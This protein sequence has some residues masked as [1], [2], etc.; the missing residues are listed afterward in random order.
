MVLYLVIVSCAS[1]VQHYTAVTDTPRAGQQS[2]GSVQHWSN[3][4]DSVHICGVCGF[5]QIYKIYDNPMEIM[6]VYEQKSGFA[7][8][9]AIQ[10]I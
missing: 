8:V 3:L 4:P 2:V 9:S 6:N 5:Y 7:D 10:A 1:A